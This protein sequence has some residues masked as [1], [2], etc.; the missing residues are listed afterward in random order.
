MP[1]QIFRPR[2]HQFFKREA[3]V[4]QETMAFGA[5]NDLQISPFRSLQEF[6]IAI[7]EFIEVSHDAVVVDQSIFNQVT[8]RRG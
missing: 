6:K 4:V 7:V 3:F 8:K 1:R 2:F 5:M